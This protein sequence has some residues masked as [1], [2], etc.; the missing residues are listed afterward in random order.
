LV[1]PSPKLQEEAGILNTA[2]TFKLQREPWRG[3]KLNK[4]LYFRLKHEID[5]TRSG[6]RIW[7]TYRN[8]RGWLARYIR[9]THARLRHKLGLTGL[10]VM[11]RAEQAPNPASRILLSEERDALGV[12]RANLS[13]QLTALDKHTVAVLAD[14]LSRELERL[15]IGRMPKSDWLEAD[16]LQWPLDQTVGNHPIGGYHHMGTTRMSTHRQTGVVDADCKVHGYHNLYIA[17]SSVFATGGWANPN[18]T[19]LALALRL[20]DHV[21]AK[22]RTTARTAHGE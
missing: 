7:R 4:A 16:S 18:L 10:S 3:V 5:P 12:P 11:V 13:W 8:V 6:R 2:I 14:V 20:A 17:G 1:L 9:P 19:I 22:L 15:G 21:V